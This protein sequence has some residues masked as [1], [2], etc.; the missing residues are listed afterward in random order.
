MCPSNTIISFFIQVRYIVLA[1]CFVSVAHSFIYI[2]LCSGI[3]VCPFSCLVVLI[4]FFWVAFNLA[5]IFDY[6]ISAFRALTKAVVSLSLFGPMLFNRTLIACIP[7]SFI[8]EMKHSLLS[9]TLT[10]LKIHWLDLLIAL[11]QYH[12]IV[13]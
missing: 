10:R 13:V 2:H 3:V 12:E 4:P 5:Y 9:L 8:L 6:Y 1:N 7:S 11:C